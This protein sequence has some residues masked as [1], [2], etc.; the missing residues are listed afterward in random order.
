MI[1]GRSWAAGCSSAQRAASGPRG[2]GSSGAGTGRRSMGAS[3]SA[4]VP[5]AGRPGVDGA[6]RG[7]RSP[8]RSG[9]AGVVDLVGRPGAGCDDLS[10]PGDDDPYERVGDDLRTDVVRDPQPDDL[11][12]EGVAVPVRGSRLRR[13][14]SLGRA[15]VRWRRPVEG[16][17]EE[18]GPGDLDAGDARR[19]RLRCGPQD[20]GDLQRAAAR[21]AGPAGGRRWW[22]S[23]RTPGPRPRRPRPAAGTATLSSPSSTARRTARSTVRE[24]SAGVTGQA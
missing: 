18:P 21:R 2:V 20:L 7:R 6:R 14:I 24:S 8:G 11:P 22:R 1:R 23:P 5:G 19:S 4:A 16:D 9:V 3:R 15:T 12:G 17:V 10:D 13:R